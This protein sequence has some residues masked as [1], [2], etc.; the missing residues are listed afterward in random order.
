MSLNAAQRAQ[1][2]KPLNAGRVA[3]REGMSYLEAY[4]VKAHLTRIFG[5]G[6]WSGE[7]LST[8]EVFD[9]TSTNSKGKENH[10]VAY[11]VVYR[12]TIHDIWQAYPQLPEGSSRDAVYTEAAIGTSHQPDRGEAHD[13]AIKTAESDALKRCAINLGTQFGLSL[14]ANGATRDIIKMT[15][16]ID[17]PTGE[18]PVEP[19]VPETPHG[20]ALDAP[21]TP[22]QDPESPPSE[23]PEEAHNQQVQPKED[24]PGAKDWIDALAFCVK[25]KDVEGVIRLKKEITKEKAGRWLYQGVTLAKWADKAVISAG[26]TETGDAA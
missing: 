20:V 4:D 26:K 17:A 21:Q 7:V 16:D 8:R 23:G 24:T 3:K 19:V 9:Y 22:P 15:L 2:L 1:L 13:M 25:E 14:Y 10:N 5:F 12:L 6:G 11:E 18:I